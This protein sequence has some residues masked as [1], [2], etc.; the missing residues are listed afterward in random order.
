MNGGR[1][2]RDASYGWAVTPP[3]AP[4]AT[5][6]GDVVWSAVCVAGFVV[7]MGVLA[8]ASYAS[9]QVALGALWPR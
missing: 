8:F 9:V 1:R 3:R 5:R 2:S 7:A 4:I 6:V